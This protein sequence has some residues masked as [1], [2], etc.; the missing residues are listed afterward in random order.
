MALGEALGNILGGILGGNAASMD[1]SHAQ[2]AMKQAAAVYDKIG[3]PPDTSKALILQQLKQVGLYTPELEQDLNNTFAQSAVGAIKEDPTLRKAQTDALTSMQ[4]RAKVGLSAE[5][6]AALNQVRSQVQQD[7]NANRQSVL[8]QMQ[9][10]GMGGSGASLV[11]QLQAGQDAQNLASSQSD[12]LMGQAQTKA[13]SALGQSANM[14]SDVRGQDFS[15]NQVKANAVDERNRFLA[16]N[17]IARQQANVQSLNS[18]QLANLQEQQRVSDANAAMQNTEKQR[19][20]QAQQDQY[21][22]KLAYASGASNQ[23]ANLGQF[24]M[25]LGNTKAQQQ[26]DIGAGVGG[27]GDALLSDETKKTNIDES[28]DEVNS[29]LERISKKYPKD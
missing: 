11:A 23:L 19:Q 1:R 15:N 20:A 5:D 29:F 4:Q 28:G 25:N 22:Q 14:A 2:D 7:A 24:Q 3:M 6:R 8:Q 12:S 9:A 27:V 26:Q 16:N 10:R 21:S 13:L 17:S 18:A